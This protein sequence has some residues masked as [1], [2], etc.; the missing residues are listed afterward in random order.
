MPI[1][2]TGLASGINTDQIISQLV[3]FSQT[4]INSLKNKEQ[5]A[6]NKQSLLNSIQSRLQTLQ[7]EAVT[8]SSA[9]NSVFD[10]RAIASS[11]ESIVKAA[12]GSAAESGVQSLRVLSLARA[13]QVASQGFDSASSQITQ[14]T[15][16]IKAGGNAIATITIDSTNNT[17][18]G[19][20]KAINKAGVGVTATVINDGSDARTQPFRLLLTSNLTGTDNAISI[21]NHLA[22]SGSGATLPNFSSTQIGQAVV[23]NTYSG[24]ASVTAN[25]GAGSYTGTANDTF[26]FTVQTGGTVGTDNG[27]QI[28]YSNASGSK[29][30]TLTLSQTDAGVAQTVI[31]GVQ[32]TL[33]AGTLTSGDQFS[34]DVFAPTVQAA[35]NA[36]VQLGSGSG[37]ITVQS[38]TNQLTNLIKGVTLSLQSADPLKEIRL[39]TTNDVDAAKTEITNFVN[40]YNDFSSFLAKQ[41]KF[42]ST[43]NTAAPL[44]GD[45]TVSALRDL[46]E[47]AI[48]APA[49]DLPKG[50]NR[51]SALGITIDER[52]QLQVNQSRLDDALHERISGVTFSDVKKLF[53]LRGESSSAGI[54]FITG[55]RL[56]KNSTSP[57]QVDITQAARQASVTAG[58][59][60]AKS[61]VIDGTNNQLSLKLNGST[62]S[63]VTLAAGT[64]TP[65]TLADE[66]QSE[67]N[68]TFATSGIT[69]NVSL[70]SQKLVFASI[71]FGSA[72]EVT[73]DSGSAIATL[74]LSGGETDHG[75]DV[76][77]NYLVNGV[78][79][80]ATGV[81]QILTGAATNS[82]TADL[83]I[84]V[85]LQNS[86]LQSGVD[87]TLSVT[88]G[89]AS[90]LNNVLEDM[91]DPV[92]GRLKTITD[93]FSKSAD[94]A[95]SA[96][97]KAQLEIDNQTAKLKQQ[98]ASMEQTISRLKSQGDFVTNS[99][100]PLL[101]RSKN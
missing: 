55:S 61:I 70:S 78:S 92:S 2:F 65:L 84:Q 94:D 16:E 68:S 3:S 7:S 90:Q 101:S 73:I 28:A 66:L 60:L 14:G 71:R 83:A 41:T 5:D 1:S 79:E 59:T 35:Q 20:A 31:D 36:Q 72:S 76:I 46:V 30:G 54:D 93:R 37:A 95:H 50:A 89:L 64:Y 26:Q 77:G 67:I 27:I 43:T 12:A 52:G 40:D 9:H 24:T 75:L 49:A 74:G 44:A 88:H 29:I 23:G 8:L 99:L 98:F 81:G 63:T 56:T 22:A 19:L 45:R 11:D 48:L 18:S 62:S 57:Y 4:R 15:F 97:L 6:N 58:D 39:T 51:L 47:R 91:L 82:H 34:V 85:T 17:L 53:T 42:D 25:S 38:A 33:G 86:Q 100:T 32:V 69:A 10:R 80:S 87:A 13:H 96:T 21:T